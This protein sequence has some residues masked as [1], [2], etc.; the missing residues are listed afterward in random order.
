MNKYIKMLLFAIITLTLVSCST[1][2]MEPGQASDSSGSTQPISTTTAARSESVSMSA[3]QTNEASQMS[4]ATERDA[5][6]TRSRSVSGNEKVVLCTY[7]TCINDTDVVYPDRVTERYISTVMEQYP[8]RFIHESFKENYKT[9]PEL[10]IDCGLSLVEDPEVKVFVLLYHNVF[11]KELFSRIK[12]S[13][14]DILLVAISSLSVAYDLTCEAD[15]LLQ[16]DEIGMLKKQVWQAHT[17]GVET[18]VFYK[19]PD[20]DASLEFEEQK[21]ILVKEEC[22]AVGIESVFKKASEEV[23][24]GAYGSEAAQYGKN[25]VYYFSPYYNPLVV[26]YAMETE[27]TYV[28]QGDMFHLYSEYPHHLR[29][30]VGDDRV[31]DYDWIRSQ[32]KENI[33]NR[34]LSGRFAILPAPF[35]M[36]AIAAIAEYADRYCNGTIIEKVDGEAL[37]TCFEAVFDNYGFSD[38]EV[39]IK[40]DEEDTNFFLYSSDYLLY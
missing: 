20:R 10:F 28:Q 8:G 7:S 30:D 32:I 27:C 14:P 1:D 29:I 18:F 33:A 37:Q 17:M 2:D 26:H 38:L 25:I 19:N 16:F 15:I 23:A 6:I 34:G 13:R 3:V 24:V 40:R 12:E 36:M 5:T 4:I 9:E 35:A 39:E 22:A 31:G 11:T 21:E